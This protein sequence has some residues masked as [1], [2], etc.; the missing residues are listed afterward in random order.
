MTVCICSGVP[1]VRRMD[2]FTLGSEAKYL[3]RIFFERKNAA[4]SDALSGHSAPFL[5]GAKRMK[6]EELFM[7]F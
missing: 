7:Y 4:N 1:I 6:F 3:A 2:I 5:F